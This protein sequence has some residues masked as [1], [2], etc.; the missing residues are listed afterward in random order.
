MYVTDGLYE[1]LDMSKI[2]NAATLVNQAKISPYH[3][4]TWAYVYTIGYRPDMLPAGFSSGFHRSFQDSNLKPA[5]SM[6]GR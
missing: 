6:S 5:G 4:G 3:I 1:M 2:P